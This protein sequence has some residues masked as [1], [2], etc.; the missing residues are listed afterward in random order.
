MFRPVLIYLPTLTPKCF[1]YS[2]NLTLATTT[3]GSLA[4]ATA[5]AV[6]WLWQWQWQSSDP[7]NRLTLVIG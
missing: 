7:G 1:D 4:L 2:S 5:I 3:S 6:D